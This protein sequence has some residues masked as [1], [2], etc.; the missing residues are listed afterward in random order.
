VGRL[1]REANAGVTRAVVGALVAAGPAAVGALIEVVSRQDPTTLLPA[2]E[3][4]ILIGRAAVPEVAEAMLTHPDDVIRDFAVSVLNRMGPRAEAAV[5]VALRLLDHPDPI[6]RRHAVMAIACIGRPARGAAPN[7]IRALS[8]PR[9]DIS[10]WAERALVVI[11]P[12]VVPALREARPSDGEGRERVARLLARL[13]AAGGGPAAD[14][15]EWVGN[16]DKLLLF[17]WVGQKLA[18]GPASLRGLARELDDLLR[19][20]VWRHGLPT[21]E[22]TLRGWLDSLRDTLNRGMN[23]NAELIHRERGRTLGLT[24]EG[25]SLLP[26]VTT[27]LGKKGLLVYPG[28]EPRDPPAAESR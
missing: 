19:R 27:Y 3:A 13:A 7:L 22:P 11:G 24:A 12:D 6:V 14:G 5:P 2:A 25:L 23:T 28:S 8:D 26:R 21:V 15:F 16:D 18:K 4:L 9:E 17:A 1:G 20:G 10:Y